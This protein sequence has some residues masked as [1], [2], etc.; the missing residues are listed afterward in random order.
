[1]IP[2][3]TR[4]TPNFMISAMVN[5]RPPVTFESTN[6]RRQNSRSKARCAWLSTKPGITAAPPQSVHLS[7]AGGVVVVADPHD[8]LTVDYDGGVGEN[9]KS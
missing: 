4:V 8:P 9:S 5:N 1:M 7:A 2:Q 6:K 3:P